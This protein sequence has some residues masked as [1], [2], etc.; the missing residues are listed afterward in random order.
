MT[1]RLNAAM[2]AASLCTTVIGGPAQ[3][4]ENLI[5]AQVGNGTV[6]DEN[7]PNAS[8]PVPNADKAQGG[9]A[10]I[11]APV[12]GAWLSS[13]IAGAPVR[14]SD[15]QD[16]GEVSDLLVDASGQVGAI[17]VDV[18]GVLGIGEKKV[19]V[20]MTAVQI[21]TGQDGSPTASQAEN[22][23]PAAEQGVGETGG[24]QSQTAQPGTTTPEPA[25]VDRKGRIQ[26]TLRAARAELEA[27]PE[28][29][30]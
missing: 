15:D 7:A 24:D 27:A 4:S 26:I 29:N 20:P 28:F 16:V 22:A 5:L 23:A 30:R 3:S 14:S 8:A 21:N 12:A 17:I 11:G 6:G 9:T 19:A 2:L 25:G 10:F 18:G 1:A 13:E